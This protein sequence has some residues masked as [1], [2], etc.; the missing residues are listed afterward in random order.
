MHLMQQQQQQQQPGVPTQSGLL[1]AQYAVPQYATYGP[2]PQQ[3]IKLPT[4]YMMMPPPAS[5]NVP[6]QMTAA[7]VNN[8]Q[9]PQAV[10]LPVPV[11]QKRK[12]KPL[13]FFNPE[14]KQIVTLPVAASTNA[15]TGQ[16]LET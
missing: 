2:G 12:R 5:T 4:T 3:M 11:Y 14:I 15:T 16:S 7:Q 13:V 8:L 9:A 6:S 1:N 10:L